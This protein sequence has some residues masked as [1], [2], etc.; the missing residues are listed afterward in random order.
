MATSKIIATPIIKSGSEHYTGLKGGGWANRVSVSVS[1]SSPMPSADYTV[2]A[3]VSDVWN[4]F[5]YTTAT[6]TSRT[7]NG[8]TLT[9]VNTNSVVGSGASG[10]V[11][12]IAMAHQA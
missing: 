12:W 6:A 5:P 1:F 9:L 8:F 2:I 10:Y 7:V 4:D 3:T 11:N